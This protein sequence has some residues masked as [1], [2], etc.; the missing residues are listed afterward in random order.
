MV[1]Y[2]QSEGGFTNALL[3]PG[4]EAHP[5]PDNSATQPPDGFATDI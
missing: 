5:Q 4:C 3:S 2:L 1:S